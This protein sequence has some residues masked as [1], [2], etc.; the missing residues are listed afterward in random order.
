MA[1]MNNIE[2]IE[3]LLITNDNGCLHLESEKSLN[4]INPATE[5]GFILEKYEGQRVRITIEEIKD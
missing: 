3:G 5:I 2:V 1:T 4:N